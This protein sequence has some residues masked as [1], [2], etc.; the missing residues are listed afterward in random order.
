MDLGC[1]TGRNALFLASN[2]EVDAVDIS[3]EALKL[4]NS[5]NITKFHQDIQDFLFDK[6]YAGIICTDTLHF[7]AI[8]KIENTFAKMKKHTVK[9]GI[10]IITVFTKNGELVLDAIKHYFEPDELKSYYSDWKII[11]YELKMGDCHARKSDGTPFRHESA[12]LV[13]QKN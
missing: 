9:G 12:I 4:I 5:E 2:H 7:L 6:Q 1:N 8:D 13:A 11:A 3:A 10:N